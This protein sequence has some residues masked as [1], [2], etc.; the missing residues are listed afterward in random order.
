VLPET[1]SVCG[2]SPENKI[3]DVYCFSHRFSDKRAELL[4]VNKAYRLTEPN[5]MSVRFGNL[6]AK[7]LR[8]MTRCY[9]ADERESLKF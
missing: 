3:D 4:R 6:E 8:Q 2:I 1:E 7:V 5:E 9:A